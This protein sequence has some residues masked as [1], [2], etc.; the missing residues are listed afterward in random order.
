[1]SIGYGVSKINN[2]TVTDRD[3]AQHVGFDTYCRLRRRQP[4]LYMDYIECKSISIQPNKVELMT[5][6]RTPLQVKT[7]LVTSIANGDISDLTREDYKKPLEYEIPLSSTVTWILWL[8]IMLF[9]IIGY[10]VYSGIIGYL[11][12]KDKYCV[13]TLYGTE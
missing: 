2:V 11:L 5:Y 6:E 4:D 10:L 12:A 8:F 3:I 1:M 7:D 13:Y 9:F